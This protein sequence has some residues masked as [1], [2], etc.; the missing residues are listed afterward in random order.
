MT[1]LIRTLQSVFTREMSS[2]TR[3]SRQLLVCLHILSVRLQ[4]GAVHVPVFRPCDRKQLPRLTQRLPV[5]LSIL[6][7]LCL[8]L[9][10]AALQ[11]SSYLRAQAQLHM[12]I[13]GGYFGS[14][15][16]TITYFQICMLVR[17]RAFAP[18][19]VSRVATSRNADGVTNGGVWRLD[20]KLV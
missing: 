3:S 18:S 7:T 4:Y 1:T 5:R 2:F 11:P 8:G 10:C 12:A 15:T 17:L 6:G 13:D 16:Q 20:G 9:K 19:A 14:G